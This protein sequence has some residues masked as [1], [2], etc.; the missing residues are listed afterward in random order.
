MAAQRGR[1]SEQHAEC[2]LVLAQLKH[3]DVVAPDVG[4]EGKL[5]LRQRCRE[6]ALAQ[7]RPKGFDC[8]Q[9]VLP[10]KWEHCPFDAII[11]LPSSLGVGSITRSWPTCADWVC[12][13]PNTLWLC[14]MER[15]PANGHPTQR[16]QTGRSFRILGNAA[17]EG[18]VW[19]TRT[20]GDAGDR[21]NL[22]S[23]DVGH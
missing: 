5:L 1:K 19:N 4:L 20:R 13:F 2:R 16:Q 17:D 9:S 8:F 14:V 18:Y 3:A 12:G 23:L 7:D 11:C 6:T 21:I 10:V 22:R 15:R